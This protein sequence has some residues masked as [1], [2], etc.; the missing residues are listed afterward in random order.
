MMDARVAPVPVR[1]SKKAP[2]AFVKLPLW[3]AREAAKATGT[4]KALVWIWLV[5]LAFET[6]SL[7]FPVP[8]A[9]LKK[10]GVSRNIKDKTLRELEAAGLIRVSRR[11]GKTVR[12]SLITL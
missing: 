3:F 4:R 12:V 2:D 11:H 5:R 7:E 9:R 6:R 10:F 8:N 1:S